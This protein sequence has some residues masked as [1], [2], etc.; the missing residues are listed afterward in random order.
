[1]KKTIEREPFKKGLELICTIP[2]DLISLIEFTTGEEGKVRK[3]ACME[4]FPK[5]FKIMQKINAPRVENVEERVN[6]L[7]DQFEIQKKVKRGERIALTA[8][9]PRH[10]G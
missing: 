4:N 8:G 2:S 6:E 9:K 5:F 7:L 10:Q 1:M 3:R